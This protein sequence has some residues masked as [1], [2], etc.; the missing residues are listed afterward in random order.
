[1][2]TPVQSTVKM[3]N[4]IITG[5]CL[6]LVNP[7]YVDCFPPK[8]SYTYSRYYK[9]RHTV[10]T[11]PYIGLFY[12]SNFWNL[13]MLWHGSIVHSFLFLSSSPLHEYTEVCLSFRLFD[14]HLD[15]YQFL[16]LMN[17]AAMSILVMV[18]L[19]IYL[20]TFFGVELPGYKVGIYLILKEI[21]KSFQNSCA[22]YLPTDS[23]WE[24]SCFAS[25]LTFT[26]LMLSH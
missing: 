2:D 9:Q 12:P 23:I 10:C 14:K 21:A 15:C 3:Q 11:L 1:M 19:W 13:S 7:H 22:I 6:V 16:V 8:F 20:F 25:L 5:F 4:I 24:F 26:I 18:F 17:V